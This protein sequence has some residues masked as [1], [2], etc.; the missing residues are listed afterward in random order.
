M[1]MAAGG[2]GAVT[3]LLRSV[4]KLS[5]GSMTL[6]RDEPRM[7]GAQ[8]GPKQT[9]DAHFRRSFGIHSWGA[10][11]RRHYAGSGRSPVSGAIRM[12]GMPTR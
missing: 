3:G 12:L 1:A 9:A 4:I 6:R 7:A 11:R 8:V 5:N 2:T 10:G